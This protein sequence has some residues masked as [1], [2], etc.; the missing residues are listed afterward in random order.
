V[1]V[2]GS[3]RKKGIVI[4]AKTSVVA[5]VVSQWRETGHGMFDHPADLVGDHQAGDRRLGRPHAPPDRRR[6]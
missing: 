4:P 6:K 3:V 5:V 2:P 1:G